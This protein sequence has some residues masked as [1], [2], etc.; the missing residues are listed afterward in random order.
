LLVK[1]GAGYGNAERQQEPCEHQAMQK[2]DVSKAAHFREIM[3]AETSQSTPRLKRPGFAREN[4]RM[5]MP[6]GGDHIGDF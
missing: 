6:R 3:N 4:A 5:A 1:D 2:G